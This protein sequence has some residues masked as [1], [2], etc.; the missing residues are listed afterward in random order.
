LDQL[1]IYAGEMESD[2]FDSF[3][4]VLHELLEK[5]IKSCM[6]IASAAARQELWGKYHSLRTS[7]VVEVWNKFYDD[8][9]MEDCEVLVAQMTTDQLFNDLLKFHC[10]TDTGKP[11]TTTKNEL[12]D[13]EE[14]VIRY[15]SGYVP[16]SLI[17]RFQSRNERKYVEFTDCLLNMFSQSDEGT[18]TD[19]SFYEYTKQWT[20]MVNRGGLFVTNEASYM[21]FRAIETTLQPHIRSALLE[22]AKVLNSD[23]IDR[24][25][26][27]VSV[28]TSNGEVLFHWC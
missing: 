26:H 21:L 25:H 2:C 22:S 5:L 24:H 3:S 6:P 19:T 1:L 8:V 11:A 16:W 14:N 10:T 23:N 15:V 20:E 27:L 4:F 17:K 18:S 28:V 12:S 13:L 7:S 9:G